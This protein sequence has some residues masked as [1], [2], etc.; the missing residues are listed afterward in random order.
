MANYTIGLSGLNAAYTAMDV[1]GNNI[2][3]AATEGYHRQTV[4]FVPA[5]SVQSAGITVGGGVDVASLRRMVDNLLESEITRQQ[6][7]YGQVS[8]ELSTLSSVE[9]SFGEFSD[10]GGLNETIDAFFEALEGLAAHPLENI[11][12][13]ET[14]SRAEVLASEFRRMGSFLSDLQDQIVLDAQNTIDSMNQLIEQI[15]ELNGQVKT[16]KSTVARRTTCG[17]IETS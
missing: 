7:V 13:N 16:S 2:A 9:T 11:Y 17:T 6:S 15:A 12:R 8:Q 10:S 14:I 3:N 5:S 4:E 1:I